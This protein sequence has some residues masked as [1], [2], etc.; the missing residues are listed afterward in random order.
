MDLFG[1][2]QLVIEGDSLR[3]VNVPV[4]DDADE[5]EAAWMEHPEHRQGQQHQKSKQHSQEIEQIR[6]VQV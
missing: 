3:R 1:I 2:E 5:K 4:I 6:L